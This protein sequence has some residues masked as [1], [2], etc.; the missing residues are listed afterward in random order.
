MFTTETEDQQIA[1]NINHLIE[2]R[3]SSQ[4]HVCAALGMHPATWRKRM[5][6]GSFTVDQLLTISRALGANIWDVLP[7][8]WTEE[9]KQA[10]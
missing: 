7:Y 8:T 1:N 5:T 4:A 6:G 2:L 3:G 9:V 10:A